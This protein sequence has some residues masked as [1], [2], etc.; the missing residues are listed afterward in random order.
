MSDTLSHQHPDRTAWPRDDDNLMYDC[1]WSFSKYYK[2]DLHAMICNIFTNRGSGQDVTNNIT[3]V[4]YKW[5]E[6]FVAL[7]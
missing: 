6:N 3:T 5:V 4:N 7:G 2:L 1:P